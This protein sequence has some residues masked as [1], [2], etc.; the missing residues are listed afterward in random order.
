MIFKINSNY[1]LYVSN[2]YKF[3]L[4]NKL[5]NNNLSK[6]QYNYKIINI[7]NGL[8]INFYIFLIF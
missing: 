1:Q 6:W 8:I 7:I 3:N 4:Y 5:L 2:L